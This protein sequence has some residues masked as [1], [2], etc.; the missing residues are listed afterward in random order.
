M[1]LFI[2]ILDLL[3]FSLIFLFIY[4]FLF[5]ILIYLNGADGFWRG[6]IKKNEEKGTEN[7]K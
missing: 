7:N 4:P 1:Y 5:F 6:V 3:S 2:Q